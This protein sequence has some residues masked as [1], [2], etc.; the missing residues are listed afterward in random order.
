MKNIIT[1]SI[2][3]GLSLVMLYFINNTYILSKNYEHSFIEYSKTKTLNNNVQKEVGNILNS[4]MKLLTNTNTTNIIKKSIDYKKKL[5]MIK[6]NIKTNIIY[7]MILLFITITLYYIL[8]KTIV[9]SF[10][11]IQSMIFLIYGLLSP[12]FLMY[13]TQDFGSSFIILQFESNSIISSIQKLFNQNN[14]F[15]GGIILLFS[16][17]FPMLKTIISFVVLHIKS[18]NILTKISNISSSL[19]KLSMTDVFV[20]SIF[21]VYLSPKEDGMIKTQ[22]EVGFFFFFVYTS[23]SLFLAILNKK[24]ITF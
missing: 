12:I 20:L 13:I 10:L 4:F 22:L 16:V 3:L 9:L 15:V 18:I 14:Y 21:L 17:I 11:Y 7:I 2:M 23:I 24:R 19:A 6:E 5:N 8:N 1:I